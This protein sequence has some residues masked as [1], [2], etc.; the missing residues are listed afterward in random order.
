MENTTRPL[1][2]GRESTNFRQYDGGLDEI[3]IWNVVRT[4]IQIQSQMSFELSG[5]E[6]GLVAYWRL[7][8]GIGA[9][10]ADDSPWDHIASMYNSPTWTAGGPM[11]P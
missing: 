10:V 8:E 1:Q 9:T 11:A 3:R 4:D 7:N 2:I 5:S 6:P